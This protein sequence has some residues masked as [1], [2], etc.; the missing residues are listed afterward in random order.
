MKTLNE[1]IKESLLDDEEELIERSIKDSLW[2]PVYELLK[3]KKENEAIKILNN[4]FKPL[5]SGE[6][7]KWGSINGVENILTFHKQGAVCNAMK[8]RNVRNKRQLRFSFYKL[9][10]HDSVKTDATK[11]DFYKSYKISYD[12]FENKF[13]PN[14]IN[15][16]DLKK[17]DSFFDEW[18]MEL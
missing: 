15:E 2:T 14:L 9:I 3:D 12:D 7:L 10:S 16:L 18:I 5:K 4:K 8:I 13:K 17:A 11:K 6:W 1:Y